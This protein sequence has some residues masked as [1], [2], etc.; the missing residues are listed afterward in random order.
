MCG[1]L[2]EMAGHTEKKISY[3]QLIVA[4]GKRVHEVLAFSLL[5]IYL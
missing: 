5:C 4:V 1:I 3:S 2:W